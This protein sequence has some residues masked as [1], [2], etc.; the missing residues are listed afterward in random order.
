MYDLE[1]G[2]TLPNV[3]NIVD[4][5]DPMKNGEFDSQQALALSKPMKSYCNL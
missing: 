4:I 5:V 2:V 3:C 1:L